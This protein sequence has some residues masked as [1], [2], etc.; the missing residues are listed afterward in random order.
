VSDARTAIGGRR[1]GRVPTIFAMGG[2]GFSMEPG[3]PAL[4]DYVRTLAPA[5][6]PRICLLPTAGG[7]SEDQI[8]RFQVAFGDQLCEPTHISLFRLGSRPVPLRAHL[9]AQDVIY[10]G[11]GS[12]IN[13]LALWRAHGI[14]AILREA[15]QAG[16]VLAG[17]SAGSMCWFEWGV[18]KSAG[19]PRPARGLGFLPGSNSVHFDGEPERRPVYLEAVARGELPPGWGVDDG[20]GLLFRGTRLAEAVASRAGA[21]AFRVHVRDGEAVEEAI[22]PRLLTCRSHAD[23]AA[24]LAVEEMRA[25]RAARRGYLRE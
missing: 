24:P 8:R 7:D 15:W 9:L 17:L 4:D 16:I 13:L 19:R 6:E 25:L 2:G 12:L 20:A 1:A 14:D 5:R 18:T 23:P 11:G 3:N 22:E 21:R 10:V